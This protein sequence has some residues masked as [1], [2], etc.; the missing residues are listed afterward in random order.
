[1]EVIEAM[2][3]ETPSVAI[4]DQV[5]LAV[6]RR[7]FLK[8]RWRGNSSDGKE[9]GFDLRSRLKD[10]CVIFRESG[11]EYVVRQL[12]ER[13][14]EITFK[15]PSHAALIGWKVGNLHMPAQVMKTALRVLHDEA[16][17]NLI[18]REGWDFTEPEVVFQP[19]KAMAHA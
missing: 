12:P 8:R 16:V 10:G 6:E 18:E 3:A 13:V 7:I 14:Y 9:F 2:L 11:R 15:T 4:P 5:I 17:G 1:M 19:L